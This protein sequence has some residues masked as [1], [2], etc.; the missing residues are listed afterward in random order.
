MSSGTNSLNVTE[1]TAHT[2]SGSKFT[3]V[4]SAVY[5]LSPSLLIP[6]PTYVKNQEWDFVPFF[7]AEEFRYFLY[8]KNIPSE[9]G[10]LKDLN[11]L[12]LF[13]FLAN[14]SLFRCTCLL[15]RSHMATYFNRR[16]WITDYCRN[17]C[18]C[19]HAEE[20]GVSTHSINKFPQNS[21]KIY[22]KKF[23]FLCTISFLFKANV[24][25]NFGQDKFAL[26]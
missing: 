1:V 18:C 20:E 22:Y 5:V 25:E 4:I 10:F 8:K 23:I 21:K 6:S 11:F 16:G 26:A 2:P 15:Q 7:Y 3:H 24:E 9:G 13:H 19:C 12:S 17:Y 14:V